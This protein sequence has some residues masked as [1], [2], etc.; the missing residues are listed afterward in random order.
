MKMP[1]GRFMRCA[2]IAIACASA[3]AP[4]GL[5]ETGDHVRM[6]LDWRDRVTR[7]T[8]DVTCLAAALSTLLRFQLAREIPE[9]DIVSAM[10]GDRGLPQIRVQGGFSLGDA[11]DFL[12]QRGYAG[13]GERGLELEELATRLPAI[14][15]VTT[16][17]TTDAAHHFVVVLHATGGRFAVADPATGGQWLPASHLARRWTGIAFFLDAS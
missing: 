16:T 5:A 11:L 4:M 10:L 1:D 13:W 12:E 15:Q 17:G 9:A 6:S 8:E 14:V 3:Q 2:A 7:Q